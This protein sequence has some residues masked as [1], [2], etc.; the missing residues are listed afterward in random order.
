LPAEVE[1]TEADYVHRAQTVHLGT[2]P[3]K[4]SGMCSLDVPLRIGQRVYAQLDAER[5]YFF[6]TKS[7]FRI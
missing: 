4:Y 3:W 7:G 1:S 2:G 5:L 6:D